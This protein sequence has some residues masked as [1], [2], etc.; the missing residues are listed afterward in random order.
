MGE[1]ALITPDATTQEDV[2]FTST[3]WE[4]FIRESGLR[5]VHLN[6]YYL[7][8]ETEDL[9]ASDYEKLLTELVA[10]AVV[11]GA[12]VLPAQYEAKDFLFTMARGG[13][14]N[15]QKVL[16]VRLIK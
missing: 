1:E 4:K 7:G 13:Y 2:L 9:T 8:S 3:P 15:H 14:Y 11:V 6:E 16:E 12:M 5:F 10:D